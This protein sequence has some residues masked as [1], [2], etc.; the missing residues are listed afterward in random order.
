[1]VLAARV[2]FPS[3][4]KEFRN[5]HVICFRHRDNDRRSRL[6]DPGQAGQR[7][8]PAS[9]PLIPFAMIAASAMRKNRASKAEEQRTGGPDKLPRDHTDRPSADYDSIDAAIKRSIDEFGA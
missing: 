3:N 8:R 7:A 5:A 6:P 1:M 2:A 4:P 9:Q